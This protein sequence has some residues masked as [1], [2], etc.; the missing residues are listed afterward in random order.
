MRQSVIWIND[1][2]K[3]RIALLLLG[4][5]ASPA[6][7][8]PP[9]T[10]SPAGDTCRN[11]PAKPIPVEIMTAGF[12]AAHPD[13]FWRSVALA[14]YRKQSYS[15]A[16]RDFK[17]AASYADKFS[18]SMVAHM[19]WEGQGTAADH[20]LAYAWMD[21]AAEREYYNFVTQRE[22]YWAQLNEQQR[23]AAVQR[24]QA[25]YAEYRDSVT[26]PNMEKELRRTAQRMTGSRTGFVSPGLYVS[27]TDGNF[28]PGSVYYDKTYYQPERYWCDQ[29]AYWSRPMNPNV[30]VG[31]PHTVSPD[32]EKP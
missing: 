15:K 18:Q 24:G 16:M 23:A 17:R 1:M 8:N 10:T 9:A 25:V 20:A 31:L 3:S 27:G 4:I 22:I 29:D 21:L 6:L 12:F 14:A 28:M 5:A 30:E 2:R 7:A 13:M 11:M 26:K 19:Y 32:V